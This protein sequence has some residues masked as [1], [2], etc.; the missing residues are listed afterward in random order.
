[1]Y[2]RLEDLKLPELP[3]EVP[4][5]EKDGMDFFPINNPPHLTLEKGI[6]NIKKFVDSM[7]AE[8]KPRGAE[9]DTDKSVVIKH[10]SM[11]EFARGMTVALEMVKAGR[12]IDVLYEPS[13]TEK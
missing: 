8:Q 1:M 5:S 2:T 11:Y 7:P 4:E 3:N 13:S 12:F 9:A 10:G 6:A